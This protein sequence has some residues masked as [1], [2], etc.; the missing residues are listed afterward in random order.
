MEDQ[1]FSDGIGAISIIGGTV[2]ID[3]VA[4]SPTEKDAKGQPK[5]AF[6][7]RIVMGTEGFIQA[8]EKMHGA[9]Q[10]LTK[11][12]AAPPPV[13]PLDISSSAVETP[14]PETAKPNRQLFP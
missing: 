12:S 10:A 6:L 11:L 3:F 1:I 8:A 13:A 2:R 9:K 7:Q 4:I 14:Q 5:V